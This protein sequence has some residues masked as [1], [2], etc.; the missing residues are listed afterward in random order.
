MKKK[1]STAL[2]DGI[3]GAAIGTAIIVPGVS[4]GTIALIS[5]AYKKITKA[6]E[7]LLSKNFWKNFLILLPYLLGAIVSLAVL[8]KPFKMAFDY[9]LFSII[10]LFAGLIIGSIPGVFDEIKGEKST[11]FNYFQLGIGA[12]AAIL[13][14][15]LSFLTK[16]NEIITAL[17]AEVPFYLYFIIFAVGM[18]GATGLVIPGFSGS[19][20]LLV[21]GF[22]K[23]I[24]SLISLDNLWINVSL[25]F[26]FAVGLLIGVILLSKLMN[27]LLENHKRGTMHVVI[28]FICGSVVAIFV[29][30]E[31]FNYISSPSFGLLDYILGPILLILGLAFSIWFTHFKRSHLEKEDAKN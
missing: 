5:G 11:K 25:I 15:V 18:I 20:L 27:F 9:C 12:V 14:G 30:P 2:K 19:M 31:M 3:T 13:V 22:Y 10:C 16:S 17:F 23:P 1:V 24:L 26:T 7:A 4:G 21:I 29:N 6:A 28:G 8:I